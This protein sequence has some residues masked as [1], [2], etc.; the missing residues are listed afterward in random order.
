MTRPVSPE[1]AHIHFVVL[2][3]AATA[4]GWLAGCGSTDE[5]VRP[6]TELDAATPTADAARPAPDAGVTTNGD[7]AILGPTVI[8]DVPASR[9]E[10]EGNIVV[11]P[12]GHVAVTWTALGAASYDVFYR[13]S[14]DDGETWGE[15]TAFARP[16]DNNIASNASLAA[17]PDG[18]IVVVWASEHA[19]AARNR[20]NVRLWLAES[21]AG[22]TSFGTPVVVDEPAPG[23]AVDLPDVLVLDDGSLVVTYTSF[24]DPLGAMDIVAARS[25][26]GRDFTQARIT[27]GDSTAA[28]GFSRSCAAAGRIYV[29][30]SDFSTGVF[31][32]SSDDRG[33]TWPDERRI[34]VQRPAHVDFFP[35]LGA[36]CVARGDEVWVMYVRAPDQSVAQ[37]LYT[38]VEIAHSPDRGA[39]IDAVYEVDDA[40]AGARFLAPT[41]ALGGPDEL[42]VAYYAGSGDGDASASF[43]VARSRD[44]GRT[45]APS[46]L[47]DAPVTMSTSRTPPAWVGDYVGLDVVDG[48]FFTAFAETSVTTAHIAF[49]RAGLADTAGATAADVDGGS[50]SPDA[51]VHGGGDA[52]PPDVGSCGETYH[53]CSCACGDDQDCVNACYSRAPAACGTC[54]GRAQ[55]A[56][57]PAEFRAAQACAVRVTSPPAGSPSGAPLCARS[58]YACVERE[59]TAE[60]D[61][62]AACF[63]VAADATTGSADCLS[64][65]A[66]CLGSSC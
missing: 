42:V 9:N 22:E 38:H 53:T 26:N 31:L 39:S 36:G 16:A 5:R 58:D 11:A 19:D 55:A 32:R 44:A 4:V 24:T 28:Y 17:R 6:T 34:T 49:Y 23:G 33:A 40:A 60:T 10:Q 1:R 47:V 2:V 54:F 25:A 20:T 12:G 56:C 65:L 62:F 66:V 61:A 41:M 43:R 46:F 3:V 15:P 52:G 45:F 21:A 57:C 29:T 7:A 50:A 13:V 18:S 8:S 35:A 14:I 64:A 48:T 30:Y 63:A 37:P 51:G 27:A 59:C